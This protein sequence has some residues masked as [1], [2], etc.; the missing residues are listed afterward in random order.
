MAEE[1]ANSS[2]RMTDTDL[3]AIAVYLK[4]EPGQAPKAL[5][6]ATATR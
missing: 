5:P 3:E 2:S 6:V 1:I 4:A